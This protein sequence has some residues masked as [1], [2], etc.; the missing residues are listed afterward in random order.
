MNRS[1][2]PYKKGRPAWNPSCARN[3][4]S[5]TTQS[6]HERLSRSR[7]IFWRISRT[8]PL[9]PPRATPRS[10]CS[11]ESASQA[12]RL[13]RSAQASV[14]CA[15]SRCSSTCTRSRQTTYSHISTPPRLRR[16][17]ASRSRTL[18]SRECTG[19]SPNTGRTGWNPSSR[20]QA[21][22]TGESM[23]RQG[24]SACTLKNSPGKRHF[25]SSL[26]KISPLTPPRDTPISYAPETAS[27]H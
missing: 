20:A 21:P 10:A 23:T 2:A 16:T 9:N 3:S 5:G 25:F 12:P 6:Y 13:T 27:H 26:T 7:R 14:H 4:S 11:P 22:W 24:I 19:M 17:N 8:W 1:S 18:S 15:A